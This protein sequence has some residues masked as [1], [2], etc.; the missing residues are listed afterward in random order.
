MTETFQKT[1]T[2]SEADAELPEVETGP[3]TV[4]SELSVLQRVTRRRTSQATAAS[5]E[6]VA[7]DLSAF[8]M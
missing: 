3:E 8:Q 4:S 6:E 1:E 2:E 7:Q 5:E